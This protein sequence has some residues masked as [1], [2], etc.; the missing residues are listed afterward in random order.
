[1]ARDEGRRRAPPAWM[2]SRRARHARST[3]SR[4]VSVERSRNLRRLGERRHHGRSHGKGDEISIAH[5]LL[6]LGER[7]EPIENIDK[8]DLIDAQA[9]LLEPAP[10][11]APTAVL[12]KNERVP[13]V[14]D[15]LRRHDLV[16]LAILEDAVLMN[17]SLVG[18]GVSTDDC[19]VQRDMY[20]GALADQ[21]RGAHD[22][23]RV[24]GRV[25]LVIRGASA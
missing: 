6:F 18:K 14:T 12:A 21:T 19:L 5:R 25:S 2:R 4:T 8:I 13:V 20:T 16:R 15:G 22:L 24:H 1:R 23:A 17:A 11:G 7:F 3:A 9:E 10:N